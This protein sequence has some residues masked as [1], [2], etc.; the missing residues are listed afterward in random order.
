L[1]IL[2]QTVVGIVSFVVAISVL[3][4]QCFVCLFVRNMNKSLLSPFINILE[5][6][7]LL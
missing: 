7:D 6:L 5:G 1:P 4:A 3:L 2:C